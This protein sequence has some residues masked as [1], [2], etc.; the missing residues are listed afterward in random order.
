MVKALKPYE[1]E[2]LDQELEN[3]MYHTKQ[4]K[5]VV[6]NSKTWEDHL[7]KRKLTQQ[8]IQ[9]MTGLSNQRLDD[10]LSGRDSTAT[11]WLPDGT[12]RKY[13]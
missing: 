3:W 12:V 6:P 11:Y 9:G 13:Y 4:L 1:I 2:L 10:L 7:W 8:L 5:V